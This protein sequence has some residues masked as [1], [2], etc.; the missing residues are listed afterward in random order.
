MND[1]RMAITGA[2]GAVDPHEANLAAARHAL[3]HIT[4]R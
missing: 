1:R 2:T 4:A 3:D